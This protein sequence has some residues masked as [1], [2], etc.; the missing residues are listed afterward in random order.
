MPISYATAARRA[1]A[2]MYTVLVVCACPICEGPVKCVVNGTDV[3]VSG[4]ADVECGG[5]YRFEMIEAVALDRAA[6]ERQS[7]L[8]HLRD[9]GA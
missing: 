6:S 8:D 2:A 5:M 9:G 4:C 7:Y 1:D 3:T